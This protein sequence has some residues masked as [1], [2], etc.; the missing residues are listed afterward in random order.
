M[1]LPRKPTLGIKL[2]FEDENF[3]NNVNSE[4]SEVGSIVSSMRYF[5]DR[6]FIS[7]NDMYKRTVRSI[8]TGRIH[9]LNFNLSEKEKLE[10]FFR[11]ALAAA[12]FLIY[13]HPR[14]KEEGDLWKNKLKEFGTKIDCGNG[15]P[16][17][18][19][20]SAKNSDKAK[21]RHEDIENTDIHFDWDDYKVERILALSKTRFQRNELK[22]FPE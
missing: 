21:F 8:D 3:S 7:K 15:G 11:G 10:L 1:P 18:D 2:E 4:L 6:D 14:N 12:V 20:F 16:V 19:I 22:K 9:W 5:Y 13:T 17:L